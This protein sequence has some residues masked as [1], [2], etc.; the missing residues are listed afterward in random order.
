MENLIFLIFCFLS[1]INVKIKG[2]NNYFTDYMDLNNTNKIKGIFVWM[3]ILSHYKGYYKTN[4]NYL[5]RIILNYI[6]QKMVSMFLFYSG[7]GIYESIKTKG[8]NYV[9][10]I[11]RKIIILFIKTQIIILLFLI[12]N[13]LLGIKINL[14]NYLL[15]IVFFS[16]IG[17]S[18]WF[19]FTILTFYFYCFISFILIKKQKLFFLGIIIMTII[20]YYHTLFVYKYFYPKAIYAIDNTLCFILGLYYSLLKEYCDKIIMKNDIFY[21]GSISFLIFIY[22]YYYNYVIQSIWIISITNSIFC[23]IIVFISL[24][25]RLDNEFLNLL[26]SHSYSIYLLQRIVMI[27][28]SYKNYFKAN[29]FIRFYFCFTTILLISLLFDHFYPNFIHKFIKK[30]NPNILLYKKL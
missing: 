16:N 29:E 17:N 9:K 8:N 10:T 27:F 5:S 22:G 19:S 15:S 7:F 28:I 2:S 14:K 12:N 6:G 21:F 26:N 4:Q 20:N 24:K 3:I 13:L 30:E 1:V 18:N 25:I 11:P 23:L